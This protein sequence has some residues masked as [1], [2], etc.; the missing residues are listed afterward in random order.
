M[1]RPNNE[2]VPAVAGINPTR[3]RP[4]VDL[5]E[6]DSPTS[7]SVSPGMT[8]KLTSS[9]AFSGDVPPAWLT[10]NVFLRPRTSTIGASAIDITKSKHLRRAA[11]GVRLSRQFDWRGRSQAAVLHK[12]TPRR[13][14]TP[15]DIFLR[16]R[17]SA[18]NSRKA[19]GAAIELRHRGHQPDGVG[20][21]GPAEKLRNSRKSSRIW[22]WIVTS[23]A[24]VGS[25]AIK[26]R[27]RHAMAIATMTLWRIPPDRRCG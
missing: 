20:V 9:S 8:S 10:M 12:P 6:P 17:D 4:A 18:G 23:S 25:S 24:V 5:P 15:R 26:R 14:A 3:I 7:P 19:R 27:G 13:E 11:D 22:A 1:R 16:P 2:T 21:D